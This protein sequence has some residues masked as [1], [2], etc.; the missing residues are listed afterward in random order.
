MTT[1]ALFGIC[2]TLFIYQIASSLQKKTKSPLLNPLLISSLIIIA[3][4][5]ITKISFDDYFIGGKMISTL[6]APATVS[7]AIPLYTHKKT[8]LKH[9]KVILIAIL[10]GVIAHAVTLGVLAF[11]LNLEP[12]IIASLTPKSV[13]T[14]IAQDISISLNGI[15][16]ITVC[17]VILTGIIGAAISPILVKTFKLDD[18]IAIGLALGTSAHAVGTSKAIET[19][20]TQ[21]TMSTLALIL[22]G[23]ITVFTAPLTYKLILLILGL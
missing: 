18:D 15:P 21:G 3:L 16:I 6:I 22:T 14:A 10:S 1:S 7:L 13:T 17:I 2:L 11:V 19:N 23:I 5:L 12:S 20:E 8:L 4:L 9:S